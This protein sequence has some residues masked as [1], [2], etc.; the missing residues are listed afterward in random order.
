M[1]AHANDIAAVL[2][3]MDYAYFEA[4]QHG[5]ITRAN[6]SLCRRLGCTPNDLLGQQYRHFVDRRH[7]RQIFHHFGQAAATRQP[8][9]HIELTL[10]K[11]D[12]TP[13]VAEGTIGLSY[14]EAG[15]PAGY[16]CIVRDITARKQAELSLQH[17]KEAAEQELAIGR[18]IQT[19]FLPT[20]LPQPDGW[21]IAGRLEAAREVAGDF[22]DAFAIANGQ[23][24]GLVVG[25]VCDKGVG[26]ALFMALFRSLIR[27]F[28]DQH[29]SLS[30]MSV[31]TDDAPQHSGTI[32]Q[33]RARLSAGILALK[34]A[35]QLTNQYI[36]HTHGATH[37]FATIFFG[38]LD[39]AT[40]SLSYID[41]GQEP[42][43]VVGRTG[44]KARLE[45][46]GPVVGLFPDREYGIKQIE[47]EPGDVL[48]AFTDGVIDARNRGR[49]AFGEERLRAMLQQP[50]S[51]A[52]DLLDQI[53]AALR[54]HVDGLDP[55]DDITLLAV[56]RAA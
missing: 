26:A 13:L 31:L 33:R 36:A 7:M 35:I 19:S 24:I 45:L 37:M 22:Y 6:A 41:A 8:Q 51:S 49:E 20:H 48:L 17:A 21:E 56:R 18:R 11:R 43:M 46:T 14:D 28:A 1:T 34:N 27:A 39:P 53:Q 3:S 5:V 42:P 47:L 25:D 32:E 2:D 10:K 12:G 4:D 52:G 50:W 44:V 23:R 54:Q 30:W 55:Y 15:Q 40:G 9:M 16:R 38:V 29:Y